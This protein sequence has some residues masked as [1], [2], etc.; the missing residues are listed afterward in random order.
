MGVK[1]FFDFI[2]G[3]KKIKSNWVLK[4]Q[5]LGAIITKKEE[6]TMSLYEEYKKDEFLFEDMTA[7]VVIP[8]EPEKGAPLA[9]KTEYW[10]AFPETEK[11]LLEKGFYLCYVKNKNRWGIDE[12]LDRKARFIDFVSQKYSTAAKCVPV[13]MS[14]GG[15]IAIDLAAKYPE[16]IACLYLDAPV[17]NFMSCPLGC[18]VGEPLAEN[19]DEILKALG[20]TI[21]QLISYR[22]M[23]MDRIPALIENRIPLALVAGDS[24]RVVP[25]CENGIHLEKAYEKTSIPFKLWIKPG[26]DHHPHGATDPSEVVDFILANMR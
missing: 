25:Y 11:L 8:H 22:E 2:A 10:P 26:C 4:N 19:N 17:T 23:P 20:M 21:S 18:G 14:C 1:C 16:K 3:I 15:L 7:I 9:L 13:G 12:D 5:S 6:I 24:D